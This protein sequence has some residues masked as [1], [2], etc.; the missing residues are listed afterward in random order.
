MSQCWLQ[1]FKTQSF[2]FILKHYSKVSLVRYER[3][4][5]I[6]H[7]YRDLYIKNNPKLKLFMSQFYNRRVI[8]NLKN[9]LLLLYSRD[10]YCVIICEVEPI[11]NCHK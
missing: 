9:A 10:N 7:K 11:V 3:P 6:I 1:M 8:K 5:S 4:I 2:L